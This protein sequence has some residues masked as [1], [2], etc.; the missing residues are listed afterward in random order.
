MVRKITTTYCNLE[1][2]R[3]LRGPMNEARVALVKAAF[4]KLDTNSSGNVSVDEIKSKY[5]ANKHPK[6]L[7]GE[8]TEDQ[9]FKEFMGTF[10]SA[11]SKDGNITMDEFLDYF[12]GISSSIDQDVYFEMMMKNCWKL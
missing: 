3:E 11:Q 9:V 6:V 12:A 8:S 10:E 2:L 7:K 4:A 1:F 5:V